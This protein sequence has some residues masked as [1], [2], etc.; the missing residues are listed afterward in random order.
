MGWRQRTRAA[1]RAYPD[2]LRKDR[3][4]KETVLIAQ[5]GGKI[6]GRTS[7]TTRTAEAAALRQLPREEQRELDAVSMAV[8]TTMR[9]RNGAL[10]IKIIDLVYWTASHTLEGAAQQ[11][12]VSS[13]AAYT[14]HNGFV[15]LVDAYLRIL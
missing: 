11:V 12:H 13:R 4:I 10:R 5:Y 9:Y 7:G 8:Q 2:L 15:E 1:I 14:W 3:E 6:G